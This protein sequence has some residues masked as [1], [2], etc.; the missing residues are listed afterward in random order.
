MQSLV[1]P[2]RHVITQHAEAV[3][4]NSVLVFDCPEADEDAAWAAVAREHKMM[5]LKV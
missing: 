3:G 5:M 2:D 1:G 4:S